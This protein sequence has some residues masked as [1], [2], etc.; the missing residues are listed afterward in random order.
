MHKEKSNDGFVKPQPP[1]ASGLP[2]PVGS[3]IPRPSFSKIP[4]P[5]TS[6]VRYV[7]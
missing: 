4:G 7:C 6:I 5:R 1:R 2:R 3:G